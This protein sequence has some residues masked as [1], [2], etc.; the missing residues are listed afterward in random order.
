ME[1]NVKK[2]YIY[3][4]IYQI[5]LIIVPVVVT[6]Y[7]ARVLGENGS[8]AYSFSFSIVTYFTLF[9]SLGFGLYSQRN[10]A[11]FQDDKVEQS[12]VFWEIFIARLV[13]VFITLLV[14]FTLLFIGVYTE[15]YRQLMW[16]FSIN[17]V[18]IVFDISFLYQGNEDFRSIVFYNVIIKVLSVVLIFILV[19]DGDDLCVYAIISAGTSLLTNF[20]LWIKLPKV[21]C[22]V[23]LS[24]LKP[25]RHLL[26]AL[27]L[28][29]PT[30]ATSVYTSLD[31]TMIGLITGLDSENGNYEYAEKIVKMILT[32]LTSLGTVF[33][34]K[35]AKK[36]KD[37][38]INGINENIILSTRFVC[39]LA[40]PFM[41]GLISVAD[42]F[43]PWFLGD[44]YPKAANL[45]KIL[46]PI[47]LFI[48]LSNIF[49][50]QYLIPTEQDKKYFIAIISGAVV[51]IILNSFLI[52]YFQSYGAAIATVVAEFVVMFVMLMFIRKDV[53][54]ISVLKSI[55]K[56]FLAGVI[57]FIP[58]LLLGKILQP[59]IINTFLIVIV[60]VIVYLLGIIFLKDD[61]VINTLKNLF[62]RIK[63]KKQTNK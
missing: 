14:Y 49:G 33:I 55:W 26:P 7:I 44:G 29:L 19:K 31:K 63:N 15:K 46:S 17:I 43:I 18:A 36:F 8:G 27:L 37:G 25:L 60:G 30:I 34:P 20:A 6:P 42:N 13:P 47:L 35:N 2:N 21:I 28:F 5:F 11:K 3:N 61:F 16:V 58:C 59:S 53:K 12:R 1:K 54:I 32:V 48:G 57:M 45:I 41:F 52:Y 9:A 50:L 40:V 24:T 22:K 62:N 39:C 38:D 23:G 4:L 56:Y 51:N 10:I